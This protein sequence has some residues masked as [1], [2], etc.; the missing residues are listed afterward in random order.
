MN[1]GE[2]GIR[3]WR[4]MQPKEQVMDNDRCFTLRCMLQLSSLENPFDMI[5]P[6]I[7]L[8][9]TMKAGESGIRQGS[10]LRFERLQ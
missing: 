8:D 10:V 2:G 6:L 1:I 7:K 4:R 5:D 3:N 9:G